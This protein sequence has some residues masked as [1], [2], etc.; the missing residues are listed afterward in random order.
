MG[1]G[2]LERADMKR[3]QTASNTLPPSSDSWQPL[4]PSP[5][6]WN[7]LPPSPGPLNQVPQAPS[8]DPTFKGS[9]KES[10]S[11]GSSKDPT[12]K[13]SSIDPT[14]RESSKDPSKEPSKCRMISSLV[15]FLGVLFIPW[16]LLVMA[17]DKRS[18]REPDHR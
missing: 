6:S 12:F 3:E 11:K 18:T 8:K 7:S 4:P 13:G 2:L 9:S 1:W 15:S 16:V 10:T 5:D 17:V 14:S